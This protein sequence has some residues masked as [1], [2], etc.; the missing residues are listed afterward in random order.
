MTKDDQAALSADRGRDSGRVDVARFDRLRSRL[1]RQL[2]VRGLNAIELYER[3]TR[4]IRVSR[5]AASTDRDVRLGVDEGVAV[6]VWTADA[7]SRTRFA[8]IAGG[9]EA[10]FERAIELACAADGLAVEDEASTLSGEWNANAWF[11]E[12]DPDSDL[13][14]PATLR[15]WLDEA[16]RGAVR[17]LG[18][19]RRTPT[20][21]WIEVAETRESWLGPAGA[22]TRGRLRAWAHLGARTASGDSGSPRPVWVAARRWGSLHPDSWAR[23]LELR[24]I[25]PEVVVAPPAGTRLAVLF[26]A[27]TAAELALALVRAVH[28]SSEA[29]GSAVG[30]GWIVDDRPREPGRLFGGTFDDT[31]APTSARRLADGRTVLATIGGPGQRRRASFRDPP[32]AW[33]GSLVV[34]PAERVELRR[35][36]YVNGLTVHPLPGGSWL[37][38]C[39]G[40]SVEGAE[41]AAA[42]RGTVLR[43][44]PGELVRACV[45]G[46]GASVS[47]HRGVQT[48]ALLFDGLSP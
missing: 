31:L 19:S 39:E 46:S 9:A 36:I 15:A 21:G 26:S 42:L 10:G 44:S 38:S 1:D 18:R 30:P 35:G 29:I 4:S 28:G 23:M 16:W 11:Q 27:E 25:P 13:P 41:P 3:S 2:E 47:S 33:P 8:A 43:T 17:P 14:A 34:A 5:E 6:R 20:E 40:F 24:G 22:G 32:A 7:D 12:V 45:A 37:L 48:P